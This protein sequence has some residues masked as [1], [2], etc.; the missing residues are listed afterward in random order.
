MSLFVQPPLGDVVGVL[1]KGPWKAAATAARPREVRGPSG[2]RAGSVAHFA[3]RLK[4]RG[5]FSGRL[6]LHPPK[7][8]V[9][10]YRTGTTVAP[11]WM[12]NDV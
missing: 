6:S 4:V 8:W 2:M 10:P 9:S 5:L 11:V 12:L 3:L 1:L 7:P